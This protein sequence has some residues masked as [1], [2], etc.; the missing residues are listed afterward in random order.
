MPR[1][2]RAFYKMS[3]HIALDSLS[4]LEDEPQIQLLYN[5]MM[6]GESF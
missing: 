1:S 5:G 6:L 2:P 3:S 4:R